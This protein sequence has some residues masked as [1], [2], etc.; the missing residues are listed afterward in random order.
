MKN[1]NFYNPTRIL[2][3]K[4]SIAEL[5]DQVP[6]DAKVLIL[7]G[8]GSAERTGVLDQ[9]R[10]ALAGRAILEFGGIEPNPRYATTLKAVEMIRENAVTF[11]L[12][13][14][15]GSVIDAT[16]F[17]AAA[18]KYDGDAWDILTSRGSVITQAVPFG[19]VLTLPA[20]GSE[21][22]SGGVITNPEKEA[23]LPFSSVHCY[24]VFSVLDPEVTYTLPPRQIANG[25]VDAFVHTTEQYLTYPVAAPVQDGFA[26]TLLRTLIELGPKA[27][28]T[29]EDYDIRSNLMWTA[30]MALNGLIG[31]GVPQDWATHMIGHEITALND[32]DHARTLAVVLPALLNDQR[33]VKREKLLQY[34]SNVWNIREGSNDE[35]IDA[36]IEATRGFFEQMGIK[37]RLGDYDVDADGINHIVNAL[38]EHGMTS[39]GEHKAI[40]PDD[41]RRI[42]EAAL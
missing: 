13:V 8:G 32:T 36:V 25:V 28:E 39:L 35:R 1:F 40:G 9:V 29:P 11:L 42:L 15:G 19:S 14:G 30:T 5:K 16:K 33:E 38:K 41:A 34:A 37:T 26:E 24:P 4:G 18:V 20:T 12:A 17:I 6:A 2:F 23:K 7:Y 22:N 10:E 21:M 27:L 3:G 31:A